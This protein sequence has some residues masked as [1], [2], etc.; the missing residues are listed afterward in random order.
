MENTKLKCPCCGAKF[1][2]A[3][4]EHVCTGVAIGEDSNLGEVM[5]PL[6]KAGKAGGNDKKTGTDPK[7]KTAAQ[8]LEALR[9]AGVDTSGYFALKGAAG[10]DI[11][12][13]M[14][15]GTPSI[16]TE[17]DPTLKAIF[18]CG[19]VPEHRLFRRWVTAQMLRLLTSKEGFD[20]AVKDRGARYQWRQ[21][22]E[23]Y[24]VQAVLYRK[25]REAWKER[26]MF[27]DRS[28]AAKMA[29]GLVRQLEREQTRIRRISEGY[30]AVHRYRFTPVDKGTMQRLERL[31]M[32]VT[33]AKNPKALHD[34][35]VHFRDACPDYKHE[36]IS[37]DWFETYRAA[38]AYYTMKNLILF[39]G[40]AYRGSKGEE[41][42]R[43]LLRD[44]SYAVKSG[45]RYRMFYIMQ[46]WLVKEGFDV[47]AKRKEWTES[48]KLRA[49]I[50][51]N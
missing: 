44:A 15:G 37:K 27:F 46:D 35:L 29:E 43:K 5:M 30:D 14:N 20:K 4:K 3:E 2:I 19:T 26:S 41:G 10:E 40:L 50:A 1:Q 22:I 18:A 6:K 51:A 25:D 24:R 17:E 48:K 28:I 49:C 42:A 9:L 38:G 36:S 13:R 7:P 34:A 21:A 8:R 39:S 33:G 12:I 11:L 23:E 31:S 16:V 32:E 47:Q 45:H